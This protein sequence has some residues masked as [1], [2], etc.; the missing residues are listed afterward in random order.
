MRDGNSV[1]ALTG[2]SGFLGKALLS[3]LLYHGYHVRALQHTGHIEPHENI[4]II[5]GSLA[6][7]DSYA[8]LL[9]G[10]DSVIH[11]GGIVAAK[12]SHD[13]QRI[14]TDATIAFA[15]AAERHNVKRFLFISSLAAR[16][17]HL[18]HYAK[19]KYDAEQALSKLPELAWDIIRPTAIYGPDDK[20]GLILLQM[21]TQGHVFMP[22]DKHA[23]ISLIYIDDL[24]RAILAWIQ[25][26]PTPTRQIFEIA[27]H[28]GGYRW[29]ELITHA[30]SA[31][32]A[33]VKL[34][35]IPKLFA[36]SV[37]TLIEMMQR[38]MGKMPFITREKLAELTYPDWAVSNAA[39][40]SLTGWQP[41]IPVEQGL[42]K[43]LSWAKDYANLRNNH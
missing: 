2:A 14:N 37:I 26:I 16:A 31:M 36:F 11:A 1:I 29:E 27:D 19:S 17:P 33:P 8:S 10:A 15:Q 25:L 43:A 5:H 23:I 34:H 32:Q 12:T 7:S 18:S 35:L 41:E 20:N 30:S 3:N 28:D 22:V 4:T 42:S 40:T 13:Y 9:T 38:M 24:V 39:F 6:D 21:I